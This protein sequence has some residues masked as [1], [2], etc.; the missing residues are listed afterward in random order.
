[1]VTHQTA[2]REGREGPNEDP[3]PSGHHVRTDP[4]DSPRQPSEPNHKKESPREGLWLSGAIL[5]GTSYGRS[6]CSLYGAIRTQNVL[7]MPNSCPRGL[8]ICVYFLFC[9]FTHGKS[10]CDGR[11]AWKI[12][13]GSD[14]IDETSPRGSWKSYCSANV[15]YTTSCR[16]NHR[17][18]RRGIL[19]EMHSKIPI[20]ARAR[21][22]NRQR[23]RPGDHL[24][25]RL[26][27]ST[28]HRIH[29]M[30]SM[31]PRHPPRQRGAVQA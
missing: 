7:R 18:G 1:M 13:G 11:S 22:E 19:T 26:I 28:R 10:Y 4:R 5:Y 3:P 9:C 8:Y 17:S 20:L 25:L 12:V 30:R 15:S 24:R 16:A 6:C 29:P 21:K 2:H 31:R 27:R 14:S 23:C